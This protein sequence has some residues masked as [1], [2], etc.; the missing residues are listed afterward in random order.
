MKFYI[1]SDDKAKV[2]L[3]GEPVYTSDN[4][5]LGWMPDGGVVDVTLRADAN[6]ILFRMENGWKG[7]HWSLLVRDPSPPPAAPSAGTTAARGVADRAD[8]A[9]DVAVVVIDQLRFAPA[10]RPVRNKPAHAG[11]G[12]AGARVPR[13]T[14]HCATWHMSLS[15]CSRNAK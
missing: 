7:C 8:L 12:V 5:L 1:G 2:W 3:N 10:D 14:R 9:D 13:S 4:R 6:R 15:I 11:R